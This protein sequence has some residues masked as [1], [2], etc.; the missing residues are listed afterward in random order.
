MDVMVLWFSGGWN[1]P[2]RPGAGCPS[3]DFCGLFLVGDCFQPE[4]VEGDE[5]GG[6]VLVIGFFLAAFHGGDGFGI[7]AV[8]AA[9]AGL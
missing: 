2:K 1:P 7:H 3:H 6:V 9:A 8:R 5:T 4:C